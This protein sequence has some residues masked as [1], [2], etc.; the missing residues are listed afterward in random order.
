MSNLTVGI[1]RTHLKPTALMKHPGNT[2]DFSA[3]RAHEL[4]MA[5]REITTAAEVIDWK[6]IFQD[7]VNSPCS[8]FWVSEER[9]A[10]VMAKMERGDRLLQMT[11]T[12]REMYH[13]MY[14]RYLALRADDPQADM[15][16]LCYRVVNSPA[17]K[18]YLTPYTAYVYVQAH[19]KK[20]YEQR[21]KRLAHIVSPAAI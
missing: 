20:V 8:R 4:L 18:F 6:N 9:A 7:I 3:Q 10:I 12:K 14:R 15:N 13:E 11:P 19:K 1:N 17:P 16:T 2:Y 21:M 5:W